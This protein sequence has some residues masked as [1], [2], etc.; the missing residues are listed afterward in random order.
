MDITKNA[1]VV[2]PRRTAPLVKAQRQS[3][4]NAQYEVAKPGRSPRTAPA[5]LTA[6]VP[7][8]RRP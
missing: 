8:T 7:K 4:H 6:H 2:P 1:I 3:E 5:L